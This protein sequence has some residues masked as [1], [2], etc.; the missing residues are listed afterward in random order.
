MEVWSRSSRGNLDIQIESSKPSNLNN[1]A[2]FIDTLHDNVLCS[3]THH[4][5]QHE[6]LAA[7]RKVWECL[8]NHIRR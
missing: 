2:E 5:G 1:G 4:G 7:A 3:D 8:S 6:N